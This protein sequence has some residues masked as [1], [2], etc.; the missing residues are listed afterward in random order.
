[1]P[2]QF[3]LWDINRLS[4]F[5]PASPASASLAIQYQN[6]PSRWFIDMPHHNR[7]NQ[8][9][10]WNMICEARTLDKVWEHRPGSAFADD[11][12]YTYLLLCVYTVAMHHVNWSVFKLI[13]FPSFP[14][15]AEMSQS[16]KIIWLENRIY[17]VPKHK[18]KWGW[19]IAATPEMCRVRWLYSFTHLPVP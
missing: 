6:R 5:S 10:L 16:W 18:G 3:F 15:W 11:N 14:A 9:Q 19:S 4:H 13:L 17:T 7:W 12:L 8:P 2:H 1:M